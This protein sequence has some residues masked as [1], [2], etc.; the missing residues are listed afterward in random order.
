MVLY[1]AQPPPAVMLSFPR[2]RESSP[3]SSPRIHTDFHRFF[4][5]KTSVTHVRGSAIKFSKNIVRR[6]LLGTRR[7]RRKNR[8]SIYRRELARPVRKWGCD[9]KGFFAISCCTAVSKIFCIIFIFGQNT[10]RVSFDVDVFTTEHTELTEKNK[11]FLPRIYT[12][13]HG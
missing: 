6:S 11:I 3:I 1:V 12:D 13:S 4:V 10:M 7:S 8:P 2:R 5:F 9:H